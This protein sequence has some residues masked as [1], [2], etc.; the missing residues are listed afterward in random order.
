M[1]S[2]HS[3]FQKSSRGGEDW[4]CAVSPGIL[5]GW[6]YQFS[7]HTHILRHSFGETQMW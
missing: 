4:F 2:L 7:E 5:K 3:A 6:G 1:I